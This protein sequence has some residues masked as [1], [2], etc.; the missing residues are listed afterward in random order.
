MFV[1]MAA[2]ALGEGFSLSVGGGGIMG[3]VFTRYT[4]R[5][6]GSIGDDQFRLETNQRMNQFNYGFFAFFDATYATLS[7]FMQNGVNTWSEPLLIHDFLEEEN[8]G[9]GWETILGVSLMGRWPFSLSDRLAVFPML[10]LDYHI[11]L[12]QRRTQPD[13]FIY[14][15][16]DGYIE[17]DKYGNA[18]RLSDF[19][20]IWI[21]LGGGMDFTLSGNFFVRGELLYGFRLMTSH[22]RKSL[23]L[24]QYE[25]NAPSPRLGGLTSGPS[26]RLSAGW[27]FFTRGR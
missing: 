17:H 8:S 6:D 21:N 10:G 22:E 24:L 7:V 9:Q 26:L 18:F 19:N 3:G 2:V 5:A 12:R 11:S 27:R 15:R 14:D 1:S 16:T 4:L 13:G 23:D 25:L 20:S